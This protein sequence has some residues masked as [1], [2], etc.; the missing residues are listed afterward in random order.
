MAIC[1]LLFTAYTMNIWTIEHRQ[2]KGFATGDQHICSVSNLLA[3]YTSLHV[4]LLSPSALIST[5]PRI[6]V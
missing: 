5:L 2:D 6:I 1:L 3:R 4:F